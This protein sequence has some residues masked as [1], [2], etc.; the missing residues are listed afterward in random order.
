MSKVPAAEAALIAAVKAAREA[1]MTHLTIGRA[2]AWGLREAN[3]LLGSTFFEG[4]TD[5]LRELS[6]V[7]KPPKPGP[8]W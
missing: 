6:G 4:V 5:E 7:P 2:V 8:I 1:G 3:D